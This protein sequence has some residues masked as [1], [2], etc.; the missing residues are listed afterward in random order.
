MGKNKRF[1]SN[2]NG[3]A[4]KLSQRHRKILPKSELLFFK[5]TDGDFLAHQ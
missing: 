1:V 4:V 5:N 2:T 3:G